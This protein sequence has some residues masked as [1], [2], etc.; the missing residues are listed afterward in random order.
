MSLRLYLDECVNNRR[1]VNVLLGPPNE[2]YVET[3]VDSGLFGH[4]DAEHFA[5]A[6]SHGLIIVTKNPAD[7][8]ALHRQQPDH[9][10]VLVIYQDN[11][12]T[13]MSA[14]D[15]ARAIQ[16]LVDTAVPLVGS[17]QALN[18]WNY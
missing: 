3:P 4:T 5:Y 9:P 18:A 10:G 1:L 14:R 13:D 7:F 6:C 12:L 8:E 11:L 17:F 15:I 16:N 2:H